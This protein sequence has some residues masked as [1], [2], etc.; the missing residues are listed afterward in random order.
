MKLITFVYNDVEMVG[1]LSE[2]EKKVCPIKDFSSMNELIEEADK[3]DLDRISQM[4]LVKEGTID[5]SEVKI[6][7]PIPQPRQDIICLGINYAAHA[8]EAGEFDKEA[9]LKQSEKAI[10][11]S[12]RVNYSPGDGEEICG[13]FDIVETLDYEAEMVVIIG[14]DAKNVKKEDVKDY[15]FGY[16]VFNDVSARNVQTGHKQWYFGKSLEGFAP[17]G[18][19][20]L[21]ADCV[22]YPPELNISAKVNGELRQDSNTKYL[23]TDIDSIISELSHGIMLKPG[24]IIATGTPS[25]VGMGLNPPKFLNDGDVVECTVEKIGSLTNKFVK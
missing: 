16:S 21:T 17:M 2:D 8:K 19:C 12:K 20:I 13:H 24:T 3:S 6:K 15:I 1:V 22:S 7:S 14:K 25:G 18:P 11:F 23:I 9:F 5:L 4:A 10:Y